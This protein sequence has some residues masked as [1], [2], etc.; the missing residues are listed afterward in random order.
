MAKSGYVEI[1]ATTE[2]EI[3]VKNIRLERSLA[4]D[5]DIADKTELLWQPGKKPNEREGQEEPFSFTP[6]IL[7]IH[8]GILDHWAKQCTNPVSDADIALFDRKER[9]DI[10]KAR[11]GLLIKALK[12]KIPYVVVTSG[13]GRPP[14]VP[15]GCSFIP[16]SSFDVAPRS[17][18]YEKFPLVQQVLAIV[19]PK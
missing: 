2:D 6:D 15:A 9:K 4:V 11:I 18:M 10:T 19:E 8:Q 14:Q 5:P 3:H 13:R 12:E 17:S 7:V 16:L 1:D